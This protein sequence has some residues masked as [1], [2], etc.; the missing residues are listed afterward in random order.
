MPEHELQ[1]RALLEHRGRSF[2][3]EAIDPKL[4]KI[5]DER[6]RNYGTVIMVNRQGEGGEPVYGGVLPGE[7][8]TTLEG[9]DW[10][11]IARAVIN[12]VDEHAG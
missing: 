1:P 3:I 4:W 12:E 11:E 2:A 6:G 9:S 5:L 7:T 8:Q 10:M